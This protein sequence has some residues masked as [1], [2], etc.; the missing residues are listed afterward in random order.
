M[1]TITVKDLTVEVDEKRLNDMELLEAVYDVQHDKP[2]E[3]ITIVRKLFTDESRKAIYDAVRT[4]EGNV[5]VAAVSEFVTA[6][7]SALGKN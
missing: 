3:V 6:A 4:P 7:I 5:P 1:K 2:M